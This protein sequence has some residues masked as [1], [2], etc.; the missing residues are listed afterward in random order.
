MNTFLA[1]YKI[2]LYKLAM[3]KKYIVFTIISML[4]CVCRVGMMWMVSLMSQGQA[5]LQLGN[6]AL[7]MLWVFTELIIPLIIFMAVTDLFCSEF[8]ENTIKAVITRPITRLKLLMTKSLACFS[9]AAIMF[10]GVYIVCTVLEMM[11]GDGSLHEYVIKNLGAYMIDLVPMIVLV[12]M[13][14]L[15]NMICKTP[16]LAMFICFLTYAVMKYCNYFVPSVNN[17]L[18][19][20]YSKWHQLWIGSTL[21]VGAMSSKIF[22]LIGTAIVFFTISYYLFDK[23]DI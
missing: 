15:I 9:V 18:F 17:V 1:S 11:F 5:K 7:E 22:L 14:V 4:I 3:K 23:K 2:E 6:L 13:S 10:F 20:S 19:T 21:P 8:Q 12:F 16:T